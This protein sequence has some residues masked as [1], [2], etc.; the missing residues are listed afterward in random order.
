MDSQALENDTILVDSSALQGI[1]QGASQFDLFRGIR[2]SMKFVNF[3][4]HS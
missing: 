1:A 2:E 4:V 3:L